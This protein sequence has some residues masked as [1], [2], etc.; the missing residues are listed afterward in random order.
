[1]EN[2]PEIVVRRLSERLRGL[3]GRKFLFGHWATRAEPVQLGRKRIFEV[4]VD[5]SL[6]FV[7]TH[8][9][10]GLFVPEGIA[11]GGEMSR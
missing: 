2:A 5:Q 9:G 3:E 11:A 7:M 4:F 1:M 8:I 10:R 6:E